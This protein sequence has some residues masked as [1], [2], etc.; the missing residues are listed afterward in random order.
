[1][2]TVKEVLA[3]KYDHFLKEAK[4]IVD[5]KIPF[6]TLDE[7][8]IADL[9]MLL[10]YCFP[11]DET[12]VNLSAVLEIRNIKLTDNQIDKMVVLIDEVLVFVQSVK[13]K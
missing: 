4:K 12:K 11:N 2:S 1:M 8:D 9:F 5:D 6:P 3:K 10:E 7:I 13:K